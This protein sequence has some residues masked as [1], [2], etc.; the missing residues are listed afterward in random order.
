MPN[1]YHALPL[2]NAR[3]SD[4][5]EPLDL[6]D[7]RNSLGSLMW[8]NVG[9]SRDKAGLEE[10][11]RMVDYWCRYVLVRQFMDPAGW[12]LQNMLTTARIMIAAAAAREETRGVHKRTDFPTADDAHWKRHITFRETATPRIAS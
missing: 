1:V 4:G 9:I 6:T 10:A 3:V 7:I 5:D 11:A 8:R 2:E 12:E